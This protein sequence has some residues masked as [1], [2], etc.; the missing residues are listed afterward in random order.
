MCARGD[1]SL[2]EALRTLS[3]T[4]EAREGC[5]KYGILKRR[6]FKEAMGGILHLMCFDQNACKHSFEF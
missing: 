5:S 6:L 3:T 1:R 4:D 2:P